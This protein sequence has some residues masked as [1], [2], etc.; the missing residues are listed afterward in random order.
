[1]TIDLT[2]ATVDEVVQALLSCGR[3]GFAFDVAE[4]LFNRNVSKE[5]SGPDPS[6]INPKALDRGDVCV[7]SYDPDRRE[8]AIRGFREIWNHAV[9][10][11]DEADPKW[12]KATRAERRA[13]KRAAERWETD[14]SLD[15]VPRFLAALDHSKGDPCWGGWCRPSCQPGIPQSREAAE[16]EVAWWATY[17]VTAVVRGYEEAPKSHR[18]TL[19]EHLC[20]GPTA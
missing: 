17:G 10:T 11:F 18:R 16:A 1:V 6:D 5:F 15:P 13:A 3:D 14:P 2:T 4:A 9:P 19:R 8:D 7:L 12:L 20:S